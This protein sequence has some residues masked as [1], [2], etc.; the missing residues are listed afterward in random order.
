MGNSFADLLNDAQKG[1]LVE[2]IVETGSVY[3]M[4]LTPAEGITPKKSGDK[5][6]NK[7][8]I[9]IGK[10]IN[11]NIYGVVIVNTGIN[12]NLTQYVKEYALSYIQCKI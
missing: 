4:P 11:N 7:L 1:K 3:R 6:R 8:F 2:S 9:V 12:P 5:S 10:D